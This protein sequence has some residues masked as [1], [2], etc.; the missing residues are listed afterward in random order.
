MIGTAPFSADG[1]WNVTVTGTD[2]GGARTSYVFSLTPSA[3]DLVGASPASSALLQDDPSVDSFNYFA[4]SQC[5][6]MP[7]PA[8]QSKG[9]E[10]FDVLFDPRHAYAKVSSA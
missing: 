10:R 9:V 4:N 2:M 6:T 3:G 1:L 7:D 8:A 5:T